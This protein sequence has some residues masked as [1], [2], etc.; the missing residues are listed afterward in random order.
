MYQNDVLNTKA[1]QQI[2]RYKNRKNQT[3]HIPEY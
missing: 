1:Q 3:N 2:E